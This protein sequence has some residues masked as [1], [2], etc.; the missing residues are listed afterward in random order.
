MKKMSK[1][2]TNYVIVEGL[3]DNAVANTAGVAAPPLV[4]SGTADVLVSDVTDSDH[5]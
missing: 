2:T 4:N 1:K 3:N 5:Q